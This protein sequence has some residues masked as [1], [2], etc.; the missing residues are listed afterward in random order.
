MAALSHVRGEFVGIF[1]ADHE[2]EPDCF[3]R[4][5]A[6]IR[7]KPA[8]FRLY[9]LASIA[10]YVELKNLIARVAVLQEV[11]S[12]QQWRVTPREISSTSRAVAADSRS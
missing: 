7:Q 9:A 2:P 12:D 4:A 8:W 5:W 1:D 6:T 10:L 3:R 11:I